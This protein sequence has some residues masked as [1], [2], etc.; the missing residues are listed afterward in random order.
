MIGVFGGTFDP[1]H[2]GHCRIGLEVLQKLNLDDLR[3][4]PC[5]QPPHRSLP[6]ASVEQRLTMLQL[7]LA[8]QPEFV[9][10]ERELRRDG[11]SYMVD[12]LSAIRA[13]EGDTPL[14]L[15][16]GSDAFVG[17]TSWHHWRQLINLAHLVI[18]HRPASAFL[19]E[20]ELLEL[21]QRCQVDDVTAL[22]GK[23]AGHIL[24]CPVTQLDISSTA[25][26]KQVAE[27]GSS[28]YLLPDDVWVYMQQQ[29]LYIK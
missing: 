17:L 25:I 27:G 14:C 19:L 3:F 10:D 22:R 23:P 18:A 29:R 4:V 2:H 8:G 6:Q 12:T 24:L 11:P 1:V 5:R 28:R 21:Y 15:V 9:I 26:R 7:A 16:L 20:G 13:E